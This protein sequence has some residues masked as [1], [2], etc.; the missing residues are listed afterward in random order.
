MR[1]LCILTVMAALA[2]LS[3]LGDVFVLK[4]GTEIDGTL[5]R[6]SPDGNIS[7][8]MKTGIRTHHVSEFS[9]ETVEKHFADIEIRAPEPRPRVAAPSSTR[10]QPTATS[11]LK[12]PKKKVAVGL[13]ITGAVLILIGGLWMTIS[14]FAESPV[15]G[16]AFLL[17]A[18]IAELAFIFVHWNRAKS[19]LL[20]Q[21]LGVAL[22]GAAI[23]VA[24]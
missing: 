17:S 8:K 13:T 20:T 10:Q 1:K 18:G 21:F 22:I 3:C 11:Q 6:T 15:W 9:E 16:I 14:A 24:K 12:E 4:D 19:P 5:T 7:I 23:L 2:A